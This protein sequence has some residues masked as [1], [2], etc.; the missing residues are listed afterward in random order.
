MYAPSRIRVMLRSRSL[1]LPTDGCGEVKADAAMGDIQYVRAS[2]NTLDAPSPSDQV[3]RSCPP[4]WIR[5]N[6]K[7]H[8]SEVS[9]NNEHTASQERQ[10]DN[11]KSGEIPSGTQ[12]N[13]TPRTLFPKIIDALLSK[14]KNQDLEL[15][16]TA[17]FGHASGWDAQ[18]FAPKVEYVA[19]NDEPKHW[20]TASKPELICGT[21]F[22]LFERLRSLLNACINQVNA[23]VLI[24][25]QMI[26]HET[27][28]N[29][30]ERNHATRKRKILLARFLLFL[31]LFKIYHPAHAI[32]R[33]LILTRGKIP[34]KLYY[35]PELGS[36]SS[37]GH[38]YGFGLLCILGI[39]LAHSTTTKC[40][41][42]DTMSGG[43][44]LA[45]GELPS[46]SLTR[47]W[48]ALDECWFPSSPAI[49]SSV[50][51]AALGLLGR[52]THFQDHGGY[53]D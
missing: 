5:A 11:D 38:V 3:V 1:K 15:D 53:E 21:F 27:Q 12:R 17:V 4:L 16:P 51:V 52:P 48:V 43:L 29:A 24:G 22:D 18:W 49:G 30:N 32:D 34:C 33:V 8:H 39:V 19:A 14:K 36:S 35:C 45:L 2:Q 13:R 20:Q 41:L 6:P 7:K 26:V 44:S 28:M 10:E 31:F 9:L 37:E 46:Y 23:C 50:P 42:K 25:T 40:Y 47:R